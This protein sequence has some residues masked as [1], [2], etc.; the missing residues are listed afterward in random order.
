MFP[1]PVVDG[2]RLKLDSASILG[3]P[4]RSKH[5]ITVGLQSCQSIRNISRQELISIIRSM[6][7]LA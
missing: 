2:S 5:N 1:K 4:D 6:P 3:L 7:L